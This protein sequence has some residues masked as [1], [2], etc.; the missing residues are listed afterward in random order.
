V[1]A[2]APLTFGVCGVTFSV[3]TVTFGGVIF[4]GVTFGKDGRIVGTLT[5]PALA[6]DAKPRA[7]A[8][9]IPLTYV[10]R[11]KSSKVELL[12]EVERQGSPPAHRKLGNW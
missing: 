8:I 2:V 10:W 3:C 11:M 12:S 1:P 9:A 4:G 6:V 7:A 5:I